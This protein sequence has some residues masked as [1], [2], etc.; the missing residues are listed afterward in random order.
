MDHEEGNRD[1]VID[2][3]RIL[4]EDEH[5]LVVNKVPGEA[6]EGA[7]PGMRDLPRLLTAQYGSAGKGGAPA[8]PLTPV[9]RLDVPVSGCVLFARTAGALKTLNAAFAGGLVEKRYWAIIEASPAARA[10]PPS[11]ELI[12]WIGIDMKRNKSTASTRERPGL[13][14]ALLRYWVRGFGDR[15][16]FLEIALITG[17][18]HQIRAQL[19]ALGLHVKGDL[20]YGAKGSEKQGG[21]RLHARS[22]AFPVPGSAAIQGVTAEPPWRDALWEAFAATAAPDS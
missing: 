13:K 5:C 16:A 1:Y 21:I 7:A 17:R 8:F 18:R 22:L 3:A 12:H 10:L 9:H 11:G 15:Y 19:A 4:Y 2:R 20:K 6:V 14:K